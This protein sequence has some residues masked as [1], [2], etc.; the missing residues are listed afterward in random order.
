MNAL[1]FLAYWS[2]GFIAITGMANAYFKNAHPM[3]MR[4]RSALRM[5]LAESMAMGFFG[6]F[7][8]PVV[9]PLYFFLSGFMMHGFDLTTKPPRGME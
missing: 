9:A 5:N 1:F 7:F 8:W 6:G 2:I 3:I 4:N